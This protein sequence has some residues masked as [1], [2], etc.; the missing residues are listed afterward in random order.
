[1]I[2]D[3]NQMIDSFSSEIQQL[4]S[5]KGIKP[6]ELRSE[7]IIKLQQEI[8]G[9]PEEE[10]QSITVPRILE[11]VAED[12]S[13]ITSLSR[14]EGYASELIS[15]PDAILTTAAIGAKAV[16]LGAIGFGLT[17][18]EKAYKASKYFSLVL[19]S[20]DRDDTGLF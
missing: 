4:A 14:A 7:A 5:E 6:S 18:A 11:E 16:G 10:V 9:I 2:A 19:S 20:R 12:L 3:A 13:S 1:M 17:V 8:S 15:S